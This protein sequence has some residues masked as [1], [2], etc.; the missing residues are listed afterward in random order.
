M[1]LTRQAEELLRECHRQARMDRPG[2]EPRRVGLLRQNIRK[3]ADDLLDG[4]IEWVKPLV[5]QQ[6]PS[7]MDMTLAVAALRELSHTGCDQERQGRR[8]GWKRF[9]RDAAV[10]NPARLYQHTRGEE[11]K[12]AATMLKKP[13]GTYTAEPREMDKLLREAWDP[14]FRMYADKPEP[15]WE[16]FWERYG[17]YVHRV[18][19]D[20]ED[21]TAE[22]L[23]KVLARQ[24]TKSAAGMEGWRVGELKKLPT[25]L[26]E[27]LAELF[28][29]IEQTEKWPSALTRTVVSLIQKGEGAEPL[30]QRPISVASAVYRLWAAVR[31]RD[32]MKWQEGWIHQG[33]HGFRAKHST[34]DVFWEMG[35][36]V[37]QAMLN[38]EDFSGLV[39]DYAKCFDKLPHKIMLKL[40]KAAG[41]HQRL[42]GPLKNMYDRIRKRFKLA[43]GLGEEFMATNG[44]LQGC[45]WSVHSPE[46]PCVYLGGG[47][48]SGVGSTGTGVRR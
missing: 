11:Y 27:R 12:G 15:E 23:R 5:S 9:V 42:L 40:A 32:A 16:P 14:I 30:K 17:K 33:Q 37:E 43:G 36:R 35:L 28:N 22:T 41:A 31:L 19:M 18:Q 29:V 7:V 4:T 10:N 47:R 2:A 20:V 39:L 25:V 26:L 3:S 45:P 24:K 13:D 44:I 34:L 48:G 21:V 46:S 1:A 38:D 6:A 8:E